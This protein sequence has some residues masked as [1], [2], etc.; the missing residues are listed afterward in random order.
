MSANDI[1]PKQ[2]LACT[3]EELEPYLPQGIDAAWLGEYIRKHQQLAREELAEEF[4]L[5]MEQYLLYNTDF[6]ADYDEVAK[7][8][9]ANCPSPLARIF[10]KYGVD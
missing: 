1:A 9:D 2:L 6:D 8:L 7:Y 5:A 4:G 3:P 10:Q